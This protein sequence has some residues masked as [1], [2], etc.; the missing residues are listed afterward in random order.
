MARSDCLYFEI[1]S[2]MPSVIMDHV[3]LGYMRMCSVLSVQ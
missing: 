2:V 1:T 3:D